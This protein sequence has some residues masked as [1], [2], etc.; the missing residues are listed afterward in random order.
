MTQALTKIIRRFLIAVCLILVGWIVIDKYEWVFSKIVVGEIME[1]ERFQ[2]PA[3]L[4]SPMTPEQMFSVAVMVRAENG[5]IYSSSSEDRQWAV[6][7]RGYCVEA[8]FYPYPPWNFDKADTYHNARLIRV[9]PDCKRL[10]PPREPSPPPPVAPP[11]G[12]SPQPP[13]EAAPEK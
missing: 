1:V 13:V 7:K 9:L 3:V 12:P 8:R 2:P 6:A 10:S 5:E 4:N 11:L